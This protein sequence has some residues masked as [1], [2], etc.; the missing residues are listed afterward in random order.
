MKICIVA[1]T[2]I[3]PLKGGPGAGA[4]YIAR[5]LNKAGIEVYMFLRGNDE[6]F[7]RLN[8]SDEIKKLSKTKLIQIDI[9]YNLKTFLNIP[10]LIN[11]ILEAN[12]KLKEILDYVDVVIYNSPPVDVALCFPSIIRR[13]SKKQVFIARGGLFNE[14]KNVIGRLLIYIQRNWFDK[15]IAVSTVTRDVLFKFGFDE[16]RIKIIHNGL[17]LKLFDNLELLDLRGA[18]RILYVGR[19][20]PI[21]GVDTL[22]HAFSIVLMQFPEAH[23]YLLGEGKERQ[24]LVQL[25]KSLN[26]VDRV[27]FEGFIP[28]GRE[29]FR[30]Y[31]S[32]DLYVMSSHRENFPWTVIEAMSSKI[33][34]IA[35]DIEGGPREVIKN[36]ENGFL[37]PVGD[38]K[39]L[40]GEMI[41]ILNN[42]DLAGKFC[43]KNYFM[44]KKFYTCEKMG[45]EYISVLNELIEPS[46][47]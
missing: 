21:K 1:M 16:G 19:L 38:Y 14:S 47:K 7:D 25:S 46:K 12:K 30:Y 18:P 45:S 4:Y 24:N 10:Y 22:L 37:F 15:V 32:C 11:K 17:D 40:A 43:S 6:E 28:P 35:S 2:G 39:V 41:E 3:Y 5:E 34:I 27:H 33:P 23:L 42:K 9:K 44:V 29:V 26:I 20:A 36:G 13:Y 8:S 31:K